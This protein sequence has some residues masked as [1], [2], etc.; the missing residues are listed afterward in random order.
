MTIATIAVLGLTAVFL[1]VQLK[2]M[3]GEYG[4]Y[5]VAGAGL[6][7]FFYG[8]LKLE[9]I[10][11]TVKQVRSYIKINGIYIQTLMKMIGITYISEFSSGICKDA[12]YG[13]LGSQIE[14]FGKLSILAVSM[15]IL[16]ALLETIQGFLS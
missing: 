3:K 4:V 2:G 7:I 10:V 13:S 12:G 16:L 11:E 8:T 1:A 9:T 14:I 5:L 6:V 15:P